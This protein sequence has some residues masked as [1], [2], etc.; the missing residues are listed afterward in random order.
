LFFEIFRTIRCILP[1][2]VRT[3]TSAD[4]G[5]YESLDGWTAGEQAGVLF[6]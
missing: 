2:N 4:K 3:P 5:W 1:A 6:T